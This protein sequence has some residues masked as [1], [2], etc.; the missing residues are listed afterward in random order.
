VKSNN[1]RGITIKEVWLGEKKKITVNNWS[2]TTDQSITYW[3]PSGE[4]PFHISMEETKEKE[5]LFIF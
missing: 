4:V 3:K 5:T 2:L 1:C